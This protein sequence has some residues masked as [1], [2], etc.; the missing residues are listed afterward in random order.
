MARDAAPH[1]VDVEP[2]VLDSDLMERLGRYDL[3]RRLGAGGMAEVHLARA[4]GPEGFQKLV[5]LKRILPHLSADP[6]FVRMFLAEARLAAILDHPNV[7]QVFD[8]GRDGSDWFFTMEYVYGE[9][10]QTIL[11]AVRR[12]SGALPLEHAVTIGMAIANGLH[13]AHD[14]VGFDGRPLQLVHRDVSPTNV[15]VTYD[16]CAKV[17]DFGIAKV[18]SRT[19]VTRAGIRKGKVPYMSP[20]QCRADPLDRRS[21]VFSL[22]IV[23]Y[24]CTTMVRLF[25]G[26]NEFGVMNR[27]VNG[28]MPLPSTQRPNYPKEL[29]RIVMRALTVDRDKRYATT[30][31]LATELEAFARDRKLRATPAAL[32]E[33]LHAV[34]KPKPFPYGALVGTPVAPSSSMITGNEIVSS[35]SG[36]SSPAFRPDVTPSSHPMQTASSRVRSSTGSAV[37]PPDRTLRNVAIGLGVSAGIAVLAL[38]GLWAAVRLGGDDSTATAPLVPAA[39][40]SAPAAPPVAAPAPAPAVVAPPVAEDPA[41]A[42]APVTAPASAEAPVDGETPSEDE[43]VVIEDD[44]V[45]RT[46]KK[47]KERA[48]EA[49]PEAKSPD[50]DS[51]LPQ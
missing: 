46:K 45:R 12:H 1:D 9:N 31:E 41:Q 28:D 8:I 47:K 51:F 10:L 6:E 49:K 44:G 33:Y 38:G 3:L 16:G 5:V 23:L 43:S 7:V 13:Y 18:T 39:A 15:M 27:I 36:L 34:F 30:A 24:E 19:D 42:P 29:E 40:V 11:R 14:R 22:G 35:R 25:D 26:D 48:P 20:E 2:A 50:L 37:H 32:G 17:S 21:D 4:V